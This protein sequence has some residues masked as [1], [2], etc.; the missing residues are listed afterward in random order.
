MKPSS[1]L[2]A[3][4]GAALASPLAACSVDKVIGD[5][6]DDKLTENEEKGGDGDE[7]G[8]PGDG[9][10]PTPPGD[11]GTPPGDGDGDGDAGT[12]PDGLPECPE[13]GFLTGIESCSVC[14]IVDGDIIEWCEDVE[15]TACEE[16]GQVVEPGATSYHACNVCTCRRDGTIQCSEENC[17]LDCDADPSA[18]TWRSK[19]IATFYYDRGDGYGVGNSLIGG[20]WVRTPK[21]ELYPTE[22]QYKELYEILAAPE[23]RD[24]V[25]D[26]GGDCPALD[27]YWS[28]LRSERPEIATRGRLS[29]SFSYEPDSKFG[30]DRVLPAHCEVSALRPLSDYIDRL[31]ES[32]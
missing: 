5:R 19:N 23:L 21:T 28:Q 16:N 11:G 18:C 30:Y 31:A 10:E 6:G 13:G 29:V 22:E 15:C 20:T 12:G 7:Q 25:H 24:F 27:G 8:P 2:L 26:G 32:Q 3:L 17:D 9:D 1:Y 14:C 4:L